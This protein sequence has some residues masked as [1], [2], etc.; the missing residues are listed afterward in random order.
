MDL[1]NETMF[2]DGMSKVIVLIPRVCVV[3]MAAYVSMRV[4]VLREAL[5]NAHLY[6]QHQL[7]AALFFGLLV[8]SY[9]R[10]PQ[11]YKSRYPSN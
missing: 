5:S 7:F 3:V 2:L 1:L 4:K 11:W 8:A 10:N 6:W 9:Y